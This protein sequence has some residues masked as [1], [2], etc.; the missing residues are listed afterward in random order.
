M[1]ITRRGMP[2]L[3][4]AIAVGTTLSFG[5]TA[6]GADARQATL[7]AGVSHVPTIRAIYPEIWAAEQRR[8]DGVSWERLRRAAR[9]EWMRTHRCSD[10]TLARLYAIG[11]RSSWATV[12]ATWECDGVASWTR[13]FLRCA[14]DHEGGRD[15]PDVWFGH[16]RGWQGGRFAGSDRV[17]GHVQVRPYHASKVAPALI[18]RDRVVTLE[19]FEVI[20]H[21]VNHARIAARVGVRAFAATTQAACT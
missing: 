12:E 9:S 8:K 10:A 2:T 21:P 13:S 7:P 3:F 16:S 15:H 18:G 20:T 19:T 17:V 11:A 1:S 4:A 6:T 14:A 5:S